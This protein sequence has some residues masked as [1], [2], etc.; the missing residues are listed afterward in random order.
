MGLMISNSEIVTQTLTQVKQ[1]WLITWEWAGDHTKVE[2]KVVA[3]LDYRYSGRT[4]LKFVEWIYLSNQFAFHE[5]IAYA[6]DR[7]NNP[8]PA[9]FGTIDVKEIGQ[10]LSESE[11]TCGHN[12]WLLARRVYNLQAYIDANGNEHLEWKQRGYTTLENGELK[13]TW[14]EKQLIR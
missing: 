4:I 10:A 12:P 5:Q 8:Y 2:N 11:I 3:I 6:K 9:K 1:A 14:Q 7:N 13:S